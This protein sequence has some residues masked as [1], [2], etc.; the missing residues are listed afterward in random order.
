MIKQSFCAVAVLLFILQNTCGTNYIFFRNCYV[1]VI[2]SKVRIE[3]RVCMVLMA[4]PLSLSRISLTCLFINSDFR[5]PLPDKKVIIAKSAPCKYFRQLRF[6]LYLKR[7]CL[8]GQNRLRK[9][10]ADNGL[11]ICDYKLANIIV[12]KVEQ[13]QGVYDSAGVNKFY[14]VQREKDKP[15]YESKVVVYRLGDVVMPEEVLVH[16]NNGKEVLEHWNGKDRTHD[17]IY[18]KPEKVVWAKIDPYNKIP[19]DVNLINNSYT[20]EPESTAENKYF[21]KFLFWVENTMLTIGSIF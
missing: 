12:D 18:D 5:E 11:I 15:V 7:N 6:K 21:A 20:T 13:P 1:N 8:S 3:L 17:F 9:R 4:V 16:F 2:N 19:M 14:K 10:Y